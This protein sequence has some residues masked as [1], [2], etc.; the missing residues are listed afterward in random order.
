M[1]KHMRASTTGSLEV[2]LPSRDFRHPRTS[3]S[4]R[5]DDA[6]SGGQSPQQVPRPPCVSRSTVLSVDDSNDLLHVMECTLGF[7]GFDVISCSD[8]YA[9]SKAYRACEAVDLL[10]TDLEMPG[11]SG[12]ELAR[13]LCALCPTMPVLIVSGAYLTAELRREIEQSKW[14]FLAKPYPIAQLS[15]NVYALL[16]TRVAVQ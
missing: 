2:K 5:C 12:I 13:E 6:N 4:E 1:T 7:M 9:A 14:R 16:R 10:I 3:L 15:A 11:R 8:A